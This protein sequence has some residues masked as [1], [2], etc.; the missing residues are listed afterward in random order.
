MACITRL[1]STMTGKWLRIICA[2]IFVLAGCCFGKLRVRIA[3]LAVGP[4]V[5][6]SPLGTSFTSTT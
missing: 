5:M 6:S 2:A 3:P 1:D 4:R